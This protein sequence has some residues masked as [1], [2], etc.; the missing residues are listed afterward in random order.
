MLRV[1][2]MGNGLRYRFRN[3]YDTPRLWC[4]VAANMEVP[5]FQ[6]AKRVRTVPMSYDISGAYRHI[7][8]DHPQLCP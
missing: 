8:E 5:G 7:K 2:E 3:S 4:A 1:D 6:D